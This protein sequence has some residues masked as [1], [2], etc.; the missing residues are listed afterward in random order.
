M[1]PLLDD[2]VNEGVP[3]VHVGVDPSTDAGGVHASP[4]EWLEWPAPELPDS[5]LRDDFVSARDSSLM[6]VMLETTDPWPAPHPPDPQLT[7]LRRLCNSWPWWRGGGKPPWLWPEWKKEPLR[8]ARRLF[9]R[10]LRRRSAEG[11]CSSLALHLNSHLST[12]NLAFTR[13]KQARYERESNTTATQSS[14]KD[15]AQLGC[16]EE[17][18]Y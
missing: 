7:W 10:V 2:S 16:L 5:T 9:V 12:T 6:S 1:S 11:C 3:S 14:K 15:K 4:L 13:S 8:G 18:N 17:T